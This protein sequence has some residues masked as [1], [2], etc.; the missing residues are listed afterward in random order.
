LAADWAMKAR[1]LAALSAV[2]VAL[3]ALGWSRRI[4]SALFGLLLW[5]VLA[6][7][8]AVAHRNANLSIRLDSLVDE[9]PI[10]DVARGRLERARIFHYQLT[11]AISPGLGANAPVAGL[12]AWANTVPARGDLVTF[13]RRSWRAL[14]LDVGMVQGIASLTGFD[15]IE[16]RSN[17]LIR[18]ALE[19]AP[20]ESALNLLR[21][22]GVRYLIGPEPLHLSGTRAVAEDSAARLFAYEIPQAAPFA[23]VVGKVRAVS[24]EVDAL[25]TMLGAD[26]DP[27]REVTVE[28]RPPG[29]QDSDLRAA[30]ERVEVIRS[31]PNAIA[32]RVRVESPAFLVVRDSYFPGWVAAVD[33]RETRIIKTNGFL[34][35]IVLPA[36]EH[37]VTFDYSPASFWRGVAISIATAIAMWV[38]VRTDRR[39]SNSLSS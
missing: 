3:L 34:R 28:E 23:Q 21:T 14:F 39:R 25:E 7:D 32:L 17:A 29:W 27:S 10:V 8:L 35:G 20:R 36:G 31:D 26:F 11:S 4:G 1:K 18:A 38:A 37:R 15:G 16:R 13:A 6:F 33:G 5:A 22:F 24:S 30:H 9:P 19:T 2:A 12:A